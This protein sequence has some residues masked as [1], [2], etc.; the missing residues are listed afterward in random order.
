MIKVMYLVVISDHYFPVGSGSHIAAFRL[1]N[2]ISQASGRMSWV[3]LCWSGG[4]YPKLLLQL[5]SKLCILKC[6]N[7]LLGILRGEKMHY[8]QEIAMRWQCWTRWLRKTAR[9]A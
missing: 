8:K 2:V 1:S 3:M 4:M 7:L 6:Y 9:W 5:P